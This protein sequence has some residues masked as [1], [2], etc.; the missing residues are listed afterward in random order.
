MDV[1]YIS[2]GVDRMDFFFFNIYIVFLAT[3]DVAGALQIPAIDI[4]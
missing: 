4:T 2:G 1:R 3:Q